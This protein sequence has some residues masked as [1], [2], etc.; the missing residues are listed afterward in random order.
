[1]G[2]DDEIWGLAGND[3]L[4]GGEGADELYG[5]AGRDALLGGAGD[6]FIE[7]KDGEADFVG[8]GSGNDV[9]SL[10]LIDRVTRDCETLFPG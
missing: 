4:S 3:G 8:C 10:D 5:G 6:D 2:G 1:M 7:A 9:A